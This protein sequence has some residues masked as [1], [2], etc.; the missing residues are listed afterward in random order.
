MN[1]PQALFSISVVAGCTYATIKTKEP[2]CLWG[3][4]VILFAL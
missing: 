3:L 2:G 4:V 1:W